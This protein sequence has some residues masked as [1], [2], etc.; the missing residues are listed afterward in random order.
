M[1]LQNAKLRANLKIN[2]EL[3]LMSQQLPGSY[4]KAAWKWPWAQPGR[5]ELELGAPFQAL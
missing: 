2:L 1:D 4:L 3:D 5:P